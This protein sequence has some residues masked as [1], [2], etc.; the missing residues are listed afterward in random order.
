[1]MVPR[2][3]Y[4]WVPEGTDKF[5][6]KAQ[7]GPARSQREDHGLI[8]RSPRGQPM[9]AL[10]DQP[11]PTVED[12]KI[13][14]GRTPPRH[15]EAHVVVEPGSDGRFWSLEVRLGGAHQYSDVNFAL[16]GVP[17][18]VAHSP[19]TWF[20]AETGEVPAPATYDDDPFA[21]GDVPPDE[22][23]E[24]PYLRYWMPCPAIGDP[25]GNEIRCPARLALWNPD[26]RKL[27]WTVRSYIVRGWKEKGAEF[28]QASLRITDAGG[29]QV[30]TDTAPIRP[31]D[32]YRRTLEFRGVR[33]IDID[34]AEH[35]WTYTYPATPTVLVGREVK[36]ARTGGW[37]RFALEAGSL[38][39]WFFRVPRGSE[40]FRLRAT[41]KFPTDVL[42]IDVCAPDRRVARLWGRRCGQRV[43]V[44]P[45]TDGTIWHL[46]VDVGDTT[47]YIPTGERPRFTTIPF[48]LDLKGV[49]PY[50]APTWEQWFDPARVGDRPAARPQGRVGTAE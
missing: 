29:E 11:N 10:W 7:S 39:H 37:R 46:R 27:K 30:L 16:V 35:F 14:S 25:D 49:R 12:G 43:K 31:S 19:E 26:G 47:E 45:G 18:Y 13:V 40:S 17:P 22:Q 1:P 50:L 36:D 33:F 9:A 20:N 2:T 21:R 6:L 15:Q 41:A 38:R 34:D 23:R 24:R 48:D 42:S 28:D 5:T 4:F 3:W 8:I 32:L 44:P